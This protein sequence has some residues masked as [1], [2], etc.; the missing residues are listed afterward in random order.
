VQTVRERPKPT[1][2]A[3]PPVDVDADQRDEGAGPYQARGER[4][5]DAAVA[6]AQPR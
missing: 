6:A 3:E 2:R 1:E 4:H 5:R